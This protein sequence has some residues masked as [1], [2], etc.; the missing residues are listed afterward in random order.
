[1]DKTGHTNSRV[2][3]HSEVYSR[4]WLHG[5]RTPL[6]TRVL[7]WVCWWRGPVE[8]LPGPPDWRQKLIGWVTPLVM[9]A[10]IFGPGVGRQ[11]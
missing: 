2:L 5:T 7:P 6:P 10:V 1:M 9:K 11:P 8:R 4:Q 3:K